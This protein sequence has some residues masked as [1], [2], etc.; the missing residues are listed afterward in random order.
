MSQYRVPEVVAVPERPRNMPDNLNPGPDTPYKTL[1]WGGFTYWPLS[2]NDNR[3]VICIVAYDTEGNVA[4]RWDQWDW[5]ALYITDI[6]LDT[7]AQTVTFLGQDDHAITMS[8][9]DLIVAP[10]VV[11]MDPSEQ[12]PSIP[13]GLELVPLKDNAPHPVIKWG[14]YT[15]WPLDIIGDRSAVAIVAYDDR[16]NIVQQFKQVGAATI[17]EIDITP[18]EQLITLSGEE[19]YRL[20]V[21]A[22]DSLY[23]PYNLP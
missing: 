16:G 5:K 10:R 17:N 21:F 8:W 1:Q 4:Q 15:Y 9:S 2:Y 6:T 20:T 3:Q 18:T 14:T 19:N 13:E 11:T 12:P 22:F 23:S 7:G